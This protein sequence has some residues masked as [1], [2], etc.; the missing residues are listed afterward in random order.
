MEAF[1]QIWKNMGAFWKNMEAFWENM[2]AFGKIPVWKKYGSFLVN[3][4]CF[5]KLLEC[6]K[7]PYGKNIALLS[8]RIRKTLSSNSERPVLL[9]QFGIDQF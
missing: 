8:Q 7:F 3:S 4:K 1:G 9:S 5:W 6:D 2:E